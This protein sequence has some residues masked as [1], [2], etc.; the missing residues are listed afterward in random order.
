MSYAVAVHGFNKS[1]PFRS[2]IE[3]MRGLAIAAVLI[4][5]LNRAWLPNG[6]LGVDI[7]L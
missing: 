3:G 7:F 5:H 1:R 6:Y 4:Y 2:D